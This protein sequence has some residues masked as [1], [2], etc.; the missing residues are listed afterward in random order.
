MTTSSGI[1]RTFVEFIQV[2]G[3]CPT[4]H[5]VNFQLYDCVIPPC[6]PYMY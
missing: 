2:A 3:G 5:S 4:V 6:A 1:S